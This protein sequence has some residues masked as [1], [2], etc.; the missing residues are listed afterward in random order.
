MEASAQAAADADLAIVCAGTST[1]WESEGTDRD[2]LKLPGRIDE[3]IS[4]VAAAQPNT[5]VVNQSGSA[6][7]MPWADE[8][9]TIVQAFFGGNEAVGLVDAIGVLTRQGNAIGDVLF[10]KI[11]PS[12]KLPLTFP[13]NDW[14]I[15][16]HGH[17]KS[18]VRPGWR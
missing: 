9:S 3:L 16:A 7:G 13:K 11:N 18:E 17:F 8:V 12:G 4:R 6:V 10:G 2:T 5:I 14:D 1:E 15:P